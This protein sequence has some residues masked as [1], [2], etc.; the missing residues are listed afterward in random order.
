MLLYNKKEFVPDP[1]PTGLKPDDKVFYLKTT[2]EI[3]TNYDDFFQRQIMLTSLGWTCSSSRK[4]DL[5]Y[6]EALKLEQAALV[7]ILTKLMLQEALETIPDFF[8]SPVLYLVHVLSNRGRLEDLVNDIYT[9]IKDRYFVGE[10]CTYSGNRKKHVVRIMSVSYKGA[11]F[12][13]SS[14]GDIENET[15]NECKRRTEPLRIGSAD[16]YKYTVQIIEDD[17]T[18]DDSGVREGISHYVLSRSKNISSRS[19]LKL[20]LKNSCDLLFRRQDVKDSLVKDYGLDTLTWNEVFG[21]PIAQ[22][23]Q[24]PVLNRGRSKSDVDAHPSSMKS[25]ENN[26]SLTNS[27]KK[28]RGRQKNPL[29]GDKRLSLD[30]SDSS[31]VSNSAKKGRTS[32]GKGAKSK[33]QE[34]ARKEIEKQ[35]LELQ[36]IFQQARSSGLSDLSKW[37]QHGRILSEDDINDLKAVIR[38]AKEQKKERARE[39]KQ[40]QRELLAEWKKPRDDL[41]C[42]DLKPL[43]SFKPLRLPEWMTPDEFGDYLSVY[44]FFKS[45][46]ELLPIQEVRGTADVSFADV[47]TAVRSQDPSS[48]CFVELMHILLMAK[49]ERADEEDGDEADLHNKEEL[50]L[51]ANNDLDNKVHGERIKSVTKFHEKIRL[52]HGMSARHLPVDWMTLTEV[53]RL[54]LLSSG[55]YTGVTTHRFRLFSRG[56]IHCFEDEGYVFALSHPETMQKLAQAS[57]FDLSPEERLGILNTLVQQLLS[58]HK[59]RSL[60][61]ERIA[62]VAEMR[63]DLRALRVWDAAQERKAKEARLVLEFEAEQVEE[64][65]EAVRSELSRRPAASKETQTLL[66]YLKVSKDRVVCRREEEVIKIL[67][68]GVNYDELNSPEEVD[69]VRSLQK[70]HY[71]AKECELLSKLYDF[72]CKVGYCQLGRDRAFRTYWMIDSLA[73][74]LV[75]DSIALDENAPVC[76]NPTPLDKVDDVVCSATSSEEEIRCALMSCTATN[77]CPVHQRK[78]SRIRWSFVDSLESLESLITACNQRGYREMELAENLKFLKNRLSE[79]VSKCA[80]RVYCGGT[81]KLLMVKMDD[82]SAVVSTFDWRREFVEML[83]DFEEKMEQGGIGHL[84]LSDSAASREEWRE[85]ISKK[86]STVDTIH[87]DLMVFDEVVL[88]HDELLHLHPMQQLAVAFLQIVQ[89]LQYKFLRTPFSTPESK[90]KDAVNIPTTTFAQWQKALLE[91]KSISS[92]A[93]FYATLESAILW[94]KSLLQVR[95]K[96]RTCRKRGV[97]EKLILCARCD[98]CYHIDCLRPRLSKVRENWKCADCVA[99]E[100]AK[101]AEERRKGKSRQDEF[102]DY[103]DD[104]ESGTSSLFDNDVTSTE[105]LS[106][107]FPEV[108]RTQKGRVIK[109]VFYAEEQYVNGLRSGHKRPCKNRTLNGDSET[110][111]DASVTLRSKK[112]RENLLIF[113]PKLCFLAESRLSMGLRESDH[114]NRD[115]LRSMEQLIRD[116]MKQESAWPFIDPV[117]AK[118]IIKRPMDLRTMMNKIKQQLYNKPEEVVADAHL[119]FQNCRIYNEEGSA[120]CG[121]G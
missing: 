19:K 52:T 41:L 57:V 73:L 65:G 43:P 80:R 2:K 45:F 67:L 119:M 58:Y 81:A 108:Q 30:I 116:A 99:I 89:G 112:S 7:G 20:F 106:T 121:V 69:S 66:N 33:Q 1:W 49:A 18:E 110:D 64:H 78:L 104:G 60:A 14:T 53:L 109:K 93:L 105:G 113:M 103:S 48:A 23:P 47:V 71:L 115:A 26:K 101:V 118:E 4:T 97:V 12:T 9:F 100:K 35:Q 86:F 68:D 3:F 96:C 44:Q 55:Y 61:D 56:A 42:D 70:E 46:G 37:E 28:V 27:D 72:Q 90:E 84:R 102:N 36:V 92:L 85:L 13:V 15:F 77:D 62:A 76:E 83:L 38:L 51:D 10:K 87:G 75:E 16:D 22:F 114:Q 59:F 29:S 91:C 88:T 39:E 120:I 24:T 94:N 6:F 31:M 107:D 11:D 63:R 32:N 82:P 111:S 74:L 117:D 25:I 50:P 98:R 5:T 95:A 40:R 8:A 21:G 54:S 34:K 79:L 17:G